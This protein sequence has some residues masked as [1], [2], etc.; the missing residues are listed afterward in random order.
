M[1]AV[2]RPNVGGGLAL[3]LLGK[4]NEQCQALKI[5]SDSYAEMYRTQRKKNHKMAWPFLVGGVICLVKGISQREVGARPCLVKSFSSPWR[6][7]SNCLLLQA[8]WVLCF[9]LH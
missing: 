5:W 8:D 2:Q 7:A 1:D 6:F 9:A 4:A 3:L